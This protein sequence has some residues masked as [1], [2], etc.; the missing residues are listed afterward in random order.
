MIIAKGLYECKEI[1]ID[2]A[3]EHCIY[4]TWELGPKET[5]SYMLY[6]TTKLDHII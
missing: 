5:F 2:V 6:V 4:S 1:E 3:Y